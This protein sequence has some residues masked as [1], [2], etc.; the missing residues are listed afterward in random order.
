MKIWDEFKAFAMRG[1]VVDM[2]IGVIIGIAFGKVVTSIVNDIIMPPLGVVTG[3]LDFKNMSIVLK[4]ATTDAV[5]KTVV[6]A[7]VIGYG[8]FISNVIDFLIVA[9][10]MFMVV[11]GMNMAKKKVAVQPAA[12][13]PVT[14]QEELLGEIRDILKSKS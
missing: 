9:F 1:N 12:P 5:G 10:V 13:A 4:Q 3:G 6:P 2:A 8:A 14:K 7:T 11:K